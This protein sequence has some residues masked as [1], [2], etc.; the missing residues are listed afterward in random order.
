MKYLSIDEVA[1]L[2][3]V[4]PS[5]VRRM[6]DRGE[7]IPDRTEGGH[8]RYKQ[9]DVAAIQRKYRDDESSIRLVARGFR[10][11]QLRNL[12]KNLL[13]NFVDDDVVSF[14][15]EKTD[16]NCI[17]IGVWGKS[18]GRQMAVDSSLEYN[19]K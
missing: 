19:D 3:N 11:S 13:Y 10:V 16:F 14:D 18:H 8:R 12:F 5:T 4:S 17:A 9:D 1:N 6:E 15:V 2:L 7:L